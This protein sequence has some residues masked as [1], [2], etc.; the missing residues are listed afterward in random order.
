[1][2]N[3]LSLFFAFQNLGCEVVT[4]HSTLG[5]D[6]IAYILNSTKVEYLFTQT[7]LV[8][9]LNKLKPTIETVTKLILIKN[10]F[11]DRLSEEEKKDL[12]YELFEYDK[13]FKRKSNIT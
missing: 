2:K 3:G 11:V 8:R 10:P 5:E 12:K 4:L 1:M 7:D 6:G 13:L 9:L